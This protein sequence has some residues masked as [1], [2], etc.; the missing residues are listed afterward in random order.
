MVTGTDGGPL[1]N[2]QTPRRRLLSHSREGGN[3][4]SLNPSR[5]MASNDA[6][7]QSRNRVVSAIGVAGRHS[8]M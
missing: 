1:T 8:R 2:L 6:A 3:P 5:R 7:F 4:S